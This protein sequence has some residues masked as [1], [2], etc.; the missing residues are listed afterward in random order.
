MRGERLLTAREAAASVFV[1][2]RTLEQWVTRGHLRPLAP[3]WYREQ[4]VAEAE[5]KTRRRP[6]L[7]RLAALAGQSST[8]GNEARRGNVTG[9]GHAPRPV[10]Q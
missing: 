2:V 7:E 8:D 10:P 4:D 5:R 9:G 3:G 6:R 1:D